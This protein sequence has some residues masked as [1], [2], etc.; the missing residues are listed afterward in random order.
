MQTIKGVT[1]ILP[2]RTAFILWAILNV[3]ARFFLKEEV[4]VC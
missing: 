3:Q 1:N 4:R 2:H